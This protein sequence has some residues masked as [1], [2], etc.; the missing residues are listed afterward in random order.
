MI[1]VAYETAS[2]IDD[3]PE[4]RWE[5]G[6]GAFSTAAP[7]VLVGRYW[8]DKADIW[9]AG[10]TVAIHLLPLLSLDFSIIDRKSPGILGGK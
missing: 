10:A 1:A 5:K 6:Y 8:D 7:E 3:D 2:Y 4:T 9:S